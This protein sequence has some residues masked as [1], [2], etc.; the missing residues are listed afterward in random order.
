[1]RSLALEDEGEPAATLLRAV[2]RLPAHSDLHQF[3]Q[4]LLEAFDAAPGGI[5]PAGPPAPVEPLTRRGQQVLKLLAAGLSAPEIARELVVAPSTV[6]TH[7]KAIYGKLGA[8]S[9]HEAIIQ[10]RELEL[11]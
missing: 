3:A 7:L 6:R 1:M 11:V 4:R 10:A 2:G 9:R 5:V 8:H